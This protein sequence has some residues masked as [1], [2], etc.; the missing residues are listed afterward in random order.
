MHACYPPRQGLKPWGICET[1]G[2][3]TAVACELRKA[4]ALGCESEADAADR[5]VGA[6]GG[7]VLHP[8]QLRE[9]GSEGAGLH[10]C[11]IGPRP[12]GAGERTA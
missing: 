10:R 8:I 5:V 9:S 11:Q 12:G 4:L 2:T 1:V 3:G 7:A 6:G